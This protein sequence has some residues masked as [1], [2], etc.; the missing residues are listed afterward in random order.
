MMLYKTLL[1]LVLAW[2]ISFSRGSLD[3]VRP[4]KQEAVP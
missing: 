3:D 4:L 1:V 2:S